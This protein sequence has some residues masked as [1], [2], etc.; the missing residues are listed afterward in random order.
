MSVDLLN[1]FTLRCRAEDLQSLRTFYVEVLGLAEGARPDFSFPGHWLYSNGQ[2]IVHLAA[3]LEEAGPRQ[4]GPL[5][6]IAFS[7][8]DL[9][10]MRAFLLQR[11]IAFDELP[12]PGFPL[13]Q[14]FLQDPLGLKIELTYRT[15]PA[16]AI[17]PE[18]T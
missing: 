8:K 10:R 11:G 5:D 13:H 15:D 2:P 14:I 7:G 6:H 12:V 18:I 3:L 16:T 9:E 4:T 17:N 1:H